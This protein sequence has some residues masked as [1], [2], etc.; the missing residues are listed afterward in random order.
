MRVRICA[1]ERCVE[2]HVLDISASGL[3]VQTDSIV[4]IWPG[5]DVEVQTYELGLVKGKVAWRTPD[6]LGVKLQLSADMQHQ[7][8][9]FAKFYQLNLS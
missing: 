2:G 7:L 5:A 6:R 4:N 9:G 1:G 3:R 8:E